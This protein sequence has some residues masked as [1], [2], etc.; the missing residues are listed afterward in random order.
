MEESLVVACLGVMTVVIGIQVFMRY[1]MQDSLSWSEELARYLFIFLVYA[2]ISYG[3]KLKR[4]IR[5]EVF[6]M[7]L[8]LKVRQFIMIISDLIF[9]AFAVFIIYYGFTTVG[10]IFR[11]NQL[12]PALQLPMGYVYATLP[13]CYIMVTVRLL[14]NLR[15][16]INEFLHPAPPAPDKEGGHA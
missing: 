7:W 2:G 15:F 5:V 10:R 11:V 13:F 9:L 8:P 6:T 12:S 14:Q 3:V 4:H 1:V 16:S